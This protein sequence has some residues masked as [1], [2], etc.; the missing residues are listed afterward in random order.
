MDV[1]GIYV[2]AHVL[3][4]REWPSSKN[5]FIRRRE[6]AETK[7]VQALAVRSNTGQSFEVWHFFFISASAPN[8][9]P[10]FIKQNQDIKKQ[11]S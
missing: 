3:P 2:I 5:F 11:M 1:F 7:V 4:T 6:A 10:G 9:V 8:C